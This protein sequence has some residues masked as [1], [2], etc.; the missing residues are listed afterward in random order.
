MAESQIYVRIST[1][2]STCVKRTCID[3]GGGTDNLHTKNE[4][5]KQREKRMGM[6]VLVTWA[7][8]NRLTALAGETVLVPKLVNGMVLCVDKL[9]RRVEDK[10]VPKA[11][12]RR[13]SELILRYVDSSWPDDD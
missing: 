8:E 5:R 9:R 6:H 2:T 7:I 11:K 10:N 12:T 1:Y 4:H 3:G 13:F